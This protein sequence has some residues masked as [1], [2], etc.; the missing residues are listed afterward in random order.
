M[1]R[2]I[3]L[4]HDT[5]QV[6]TD[7]A[8]ELAAGGLA[9]IPTDTVYGLAAPAF[10]PGALEHV[11]ELKRRDPGKQ[12]VVMAGNINALLNLADRE[13]YLRLLRIAPAWPGPLTVVALRS[14]DPILDSI[15]PG[16]TIGMRIPDNAFTLAL[17][18][19][20]GPLAVTSANPSGGKA[21]I[22]FDEV[23]GEMLEAVAV[24]VD[25][26]DCTS[27][28]PSTILDITSPVPRILRRGPL[29]RETLEEIIGE[30]L[31]DLEDVAQKP[32]PNGSHRKQ[33]DS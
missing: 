18:K 33:G 8:L 1:A 14:A 23:D 10:S 3:K 9:I 7:V 28:E 30:P 19:A 11:Y 32:Q 27:G 5:M 26:G 17:L 16:A 20:A 6:V 21:P 12:L 4:G 2:I 22:R 31:E 29:R 15:A 24:A 25:A 13:S